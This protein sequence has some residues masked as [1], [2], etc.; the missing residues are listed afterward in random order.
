MRAVSCYVHVPFC[1]HI[2]YYCGFCRQKYNEAFEQAWLNQI[3]KEIDDKH[4]TQLETLYFGGGTPNVLSASGLKRLC[5]MFRPYLDNVYEWTIEC[6]P[7]LVTYDQ[8]KM[9]KQMGINRISLGVQTLNNSLLK[10]IGRH[11][12][13]DDVFEAI[14][15]CFE[16]DIRNVSVDLMF[17]LPNQTI[18]DIK[19]DLQQIVQLN[20]PHLSI[21]SLQIEENSIFQKQ[22]IQP[23]DE[24][25]EADMYEMIVQFCKQNGFT[26][27]EISSFAKDKF[28]SKHNMKYWSDQDFI[29]IG[30]GACGKEKGTLYE[31]TKNLNVYLQK[32]PCPT[33]IQEDIKEQSFDSIMM[34]LRTIFGLDIQQWENKYQMNFRKQYQKVLQQYIPDHLQIINGHLIP[35]EK[36]FEILN[37]ILVDFLEIH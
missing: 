36:G 1:R 32:G 19:K 10:S 27:Y 34:S 15:L 7:E 20:V 17:A 29:G 4:L 33:L 23:I 35:T 8:V 3:Q 14:E 21:Y 26:H 11:H 18:N 31:N 30:C 16:Q 6:N 25:L 37:T 5:E 28:F 22:N 9:F 13:S 12:T 2:C 24:D